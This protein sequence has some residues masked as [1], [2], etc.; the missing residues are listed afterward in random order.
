[1]EGGPRGPLHRHHHRLRKQKRD[2]YSRRNYCKAKK[3]TKVEG[4]NHQGMTKWLHSVWAAGISTHSSSR[5]LVSKDQNNQFSS[6]NNH[7]SIFFHQELLQ[8]GT[9]ISGSHWSCNAFPEAYKHPLRKFATACILWFSLLTLTL[10]TIANTQLSCMCSKTIASTRWRPRPTNLDFCSGFTVELFDSDRPLPLGL[11]LLINYS[12]DKNAYGV[13]INEA[14]F[15]SLQL[16]GADSDS[17]HKLLSPRVCPDNQR[18]VGF[19]NELVNGALQI[20][21]TR[22][23]LQNQLELTRDTM[24]R[25]KFLR[26]KKTKSKKRQN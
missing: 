26:Q 19:L 3:Q 20:R 13:Y 9:Q 21:Q 8:V 12:N 25:I 5:Q 14:L 24:A 1:M 10:V 16:T 15:W 4:Q 23:K 6:H 11:S 18:Q 22:H 17:L 7:T 2:N